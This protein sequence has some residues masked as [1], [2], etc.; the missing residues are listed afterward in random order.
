[1][2]LGLKLPMLNLQVIL[3]EAFGTNWPYGQ[4]FSYSYSRLFLLLSLACMVA[5]I[6]GSLVVD[7]WFS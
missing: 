7:P 1:M 2:V 4:T 3:L 5:Q 6:C